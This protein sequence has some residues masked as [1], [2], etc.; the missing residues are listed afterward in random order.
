MRISTAWVFRQGLDAIVSQEASLATLQQQIASGRR[1]LRPSDDPI[2]AARVA[3]LRRSLQE[4]EQ[5]QRNA[6]VVRNRLS[7]EEDVLRSV[8]DT[9]QRVRELVIQANTASQ[10]DETRGMIANELRELRNGLVP[11]AN[12]SDGQGGYLFGGYRTGSPPFV[13]NGGTVS[14]AGDEGQRFVRIGADNQVPDGDPGSAV[15]VRIANGNGTFVVKADAANTGTAVVGETSITD[16]SAWDGGTYDIVFLDDTNYEVREGAT[17]VGS[18]AYAPGDAIEFR[19][20]ALGVDGT[21][22]A[23]DRFR[24][25]A[26]ASQSMF[27]TLDNIIR[28]LETPAPDPA[29]RARLQNDLNRGLG[30]IDQAVGQVLRIRSTV[31]SRLQ[32]VERQVDDNDFVRIEL[33]R[34]VGE[35]ESVDY[36]EALT[37]LTQQAATL[38]AAQQSFV[39]LQSLGLFNLL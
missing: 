23:G 1:I 37:R 34:G 3:D 18:G 33:Q 21:P 38:E 28:A 39:R 8:G 19:G 12:S 30:D 10:S 32:A 26:S 11:L 36:S 24:L 29:A 6:E 16:P 27:A 25:G 35:L 7:L 15:F 22:A 14:Y 5:F 13:S 4:V 20:A 9:L 31:G 17:V 2:G